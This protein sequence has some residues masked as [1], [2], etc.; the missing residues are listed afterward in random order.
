MELLRRLWHSYVYSN[1]NAHVKQAWVLLC[2]PRGFSGCPTFWL[3]ADVFGAFGVLARCVLG[4]IYESVALAALEVGAELLC[5]T[6]RTIIG[7][8]GQIVSK[9]Y[10]SSCD[11]KLE[12][13]TTQFAIM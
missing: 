13:Q 10:H 12:R 4:V 2:Q 7:K 1:K 6:M 5:R 8:Q 9:Y 3:A 11:C